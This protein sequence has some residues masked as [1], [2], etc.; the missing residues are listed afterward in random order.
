MHVSPATFPRAKKIASVHNHHGKKRTD[1]YAWLRSENYP[2]INKSEI[3]DYLHAE[4]AWFDQQMAPLQETTGLLFEEMKAR[5]KLDD[6]SVPVRKGKWLYHWRFSA[7][8][9][10][11][12]WY[13]SKPGEHLEQLILD[14]VALA[15]GEE[16]FTLGCFV[17]SPCGHYLAW[18]ADFNG[19]ER[20]KLSIRDLRT[21][22]DLDVQIP[23]ILG[24][25]VWQSDSR[26]FAYTPVNEAWRTQEVRLHALGDLATDS[27]L[28]LYREQDDGFRVSIS[29][30]TD[31]RFAFIHTGHHDS[32]ESYFIPLEA[33]CSN[34]ICIVPRREKVRYIP[35]SHKTG[36]YLL[37]NDTHSNFRLL[38][39]PV[40]EG[41]DDPLDIIEE[42]IAPEDDRY[43]LAHHC[44]D[45]VLVVESRIKGRE[46]VHLGDYQGDF[47]EITFPEECCAVNVEGNYEPHVEQLRLRYESL[48]TPTTVY[49]YDLERRTLLVRKRQEIPS[50]YATKDYESKRLMIPARDGALVPVSIVY[51]KD[52]YNDGVAPL[53]LYG[54][55][56]YGLGVRPRFS[57]ARLTLLN[58]G[59]AFAI[60]HIRGGD[61]LGYDWYLQ[62]KAEN[63]WNSFNDFLDCADGL[64]A[65]GL[66]KKGQIAI[67][68][69]SAG[70]KL[71]GV[72][73]NERP[74]LW[75][76]ACAHVPFVDVLNTMLDDSLPL[77]PG[78]WPEWGNPI[79][80]AR[81]YDLIASYSPYDQVKAQNYP[82]IFVT[83]GLYDPRVTYWE[84]AKWVARLREMKTDQSPLIL[85]TY[86]E[87]G[88]AG[89]SGR[90]DGL[91][92]LALEYAFILKQFDLC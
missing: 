92:E 25:V 28:L 86:M 81:A 56:A 85:K 90:F 80:S 7:N 70:G 87:A 18:S 27:D 73:L 72:A 23:P 45:N 16:F 53:F 84:P 33:L 78:E 1:P 34:P 12:R 58:R 14:E 37:I 63:R 67:S 8:E 46:S 30:S 71:I 22:E 59:F 36:L 82:A 15:E 11:R 91:K 62:G 66:A 65:R 29:V 83:A 41:S 50:G 48:V 51:R 89:K 4:N 17:P 32:S 6:A 57:A 75:R 39:C 88:H 10:Y 61:D 5:I 35:D 19:S 44:H 77:T 9:D 64:C 60:A 79:E 24:D 68:G 54:Y 49:D 2:D 31:K 3:L 40:K 55:G 21:G 69:G 47:D 43:L 74:E 38:R 42:V 13:R 20:F 52:A 26:A 76:V